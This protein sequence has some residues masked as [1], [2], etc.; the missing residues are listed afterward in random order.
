MVQITDTEVYKALG[1]GANTVPFDRFFYRGILRLKNLEEDKKPAR[2]YYIIELKGGK[3]EQAEVA[4][5]DAKPE[6]DNNHKPLLD[7]KGNWIAYKG[8]KD[9]VTDRSYND[10]SKEPSN[11][12]SDKTML[13][14]LAGKFYDT[15]GSSKSKVKHKV[16]VYD[17]PLFITTL[18]E[19]VNTFTKKLGLGFWEYAI[20]LEGSESDRLVPTGVFIGLDSIKDWDAPKARPEDMYD[21]IKEKESE[22][23]H[24]PYFIAQW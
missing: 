10:L 3:S 12:Y 17:K 7:E 23:N 11:K 4:V 1:I 8:Y 22:H 15:Y 16:R 21:Y 19:G 6:Y 24:N 18:E 5:F 20:N 2:P 9:V 14:R 13:S